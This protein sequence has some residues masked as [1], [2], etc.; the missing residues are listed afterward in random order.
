ML[1]NFMDISS[2][3]PPFGTLYGHSVNL[4]VIL[5]YFSRFGIFF[6]FLVRCTEKNLAA[7]GNPGKGARQAVLPDLYIP[8]RW[9]IYQIAAKLPSGYKIHP[10]AAIYLNVQ[11]INQPFP[12]QGPAKFTQ[13]GLKICHLAALAA[14]RREFFPRCRRR[15]RRKKKKKYK[16]RSPLRRRLN[17]RPTAAAGS[18][19][20]GDLKKTNP[21]FIF[22]GKKGF[23]FHQQNRTKWK[24]SSLDTFSSCALSWRR[25]ARPPTGRCYPTCRWTNSVHRSKRFS[26]TGA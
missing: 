14:S 15:E 12:F 19:G 16:N 18:T 9:K 25:A 6:P 24:S 5:V 4:V 11:R 1:V 13:I 10:K 22:G 23:T 20:S 21:V 17:D 3:L 26:C 8:N 7:Q 2:I